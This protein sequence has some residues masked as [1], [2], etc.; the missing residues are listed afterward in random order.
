MQG[1]LLP[2][3]ELEA[4]DTL[5]TEFGVRMHVDKI[6]RMMD[7]LNMIEL[8]ERYATPRIVFCVTRSTFC[9]TMLRRCI[10]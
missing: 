9:F 6:Y 1:L 2:T 8:G 10:L 4:I 3:S 5:A 7:Q